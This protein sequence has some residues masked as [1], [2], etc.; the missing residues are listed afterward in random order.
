MERGECSPL[1][2]STLLIA[3]TRMRK[4]IR[5]GNRDNN[6]EV[7]ELRTEAKKVEDMEKKA[8][9]YAEKNY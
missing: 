2:K 9:E 4:T 3:K 8:E 1:Y 6:V 5:H 7:S